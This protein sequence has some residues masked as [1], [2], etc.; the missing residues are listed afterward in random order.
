MKIS[1][2]IHDVVSDL[3]DIFIA[4]G[5][6]A[7]SDIDKI[8]VKTQKRKPGGYS[9]AFDELWKL[10]PPR[11]T[12]GGE[13]VKVGKAAAFNEYLRVEK[14]VPHEHLLALVRKYAHAHPDGKFVKDME[15]WLRGKPWEDEV[16]EVAQPEY[17]SW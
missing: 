16:V 12:D 7:Q 2:N 3:L 13:R 1:R 9:P 6:L 10:Y 15:R 17:R 4:K 8:L 5:Y 11:L 14:D